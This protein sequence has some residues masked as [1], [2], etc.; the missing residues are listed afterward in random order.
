MLKRYRADLHVHTCLSP[1]ADVKMSPLAVVK[2]A[3]TLGIDILGICDHNSAENAPAALE[4]ARRYGLHVLPGIEV[5]SS[6]EVH[7]LALF[8]TLEGAWELQETVYQN[9][10][11][12]NDEET[13]GMQVVSDAE[14]LVL[15]F[16]SRLLIGATTLR[17]DEIVKAIHALD[18]LAVAA[19]ID[20]ES[21]SLISQ[22]GFV[23]NDLNLDA[24]EISPRMS[25]EEAVRSYAP[26][27]PLIQSSDAHK[28]REIGRCCPTFFIERASVE[29]IRKALE[30]RQGRR[31]IR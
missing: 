18:G 8:D 16:N 11:G 5:T 27:L 30:E 19:H 21:F 28:V 17:V 12:E 22:L 31:T 29:E 23:P 14:D 9:L 4:A 1:C 10:P 2:R 15:G 20:R 24:L 13:F 7:I 26:S 3:Q 6:E 25:L